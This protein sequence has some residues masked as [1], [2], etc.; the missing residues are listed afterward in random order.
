[1]LE[2]HR[3]YIKME[4]QFPETLEAKV[5]EQSLKRANRKLKQATASLFSAGAP[6]VTWPHR[7]LLGREL[8]SAPAALKTHLASMSFSGD[9]ARACFS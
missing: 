1:M 4:V 7:T 5:E 6:M 2:R 3:R 9:P 8:N